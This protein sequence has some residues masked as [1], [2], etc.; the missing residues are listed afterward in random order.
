MRQL[1]FA[2]DP[3][4]GLCLAVASTVA[5]AI[6]SAVLTA[7]LEKKLTSPEHQQ[8]AKGLS[9]EPRVIKRDEYKKFLK[10]N[11]VSTKTLMGW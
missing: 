1:A 9:L 10:D 2:T 6:K 11:E 8:K 7:A 4:G 5:R 3:A